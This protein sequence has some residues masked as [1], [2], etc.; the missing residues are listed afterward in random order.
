MSAQRVPKRSPRL[1]YGWIIVAAMALMGFTQSAETFNV[2]G[3]FLKPL[4]QE[5][6][7]SR[8]DF[9]G[10]TSLGSLLGGVIALGIGPMMDRFGARV[11]LVLSLTILGAVFLLMVWM[12]SLWQFYAL[13]VTG[14]ML[15]NGVLGVAS[16]IIIPKWFIAKRG[17]AVAVGGLGTGLGNTFTPLYTQLLVST[18]GWRSAAATVGGAIWAISLLPVAIFLRRQPEDLGLLPDGAQPD[19]DPRRAGGAPVSRA[20]ETSYPL[21]EVV[22]FSSFYLLVASVC[23]TWFIRTG[24]TLHMIA[25]FTDRGLTPGMAV[26]ALAVNSACAGVAGIG[27]GLSAERYPA[28]KSLTVGSLLVGAGLL[29]LMRV[30]SGPE[31]LLWGVYWG[32][33]QASSNT[34]QRVIFADYFGRRHLGAIQGVVRS[35]QT[36]AQALGPLVAALAY[37]GSGSYQPVFLV[38]AAAAVVGAVCVFAARPPVRGPGITA[39]GSTQERVVRR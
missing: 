31:A 26:M 5:F 25:Y 6:G 28:R 30:D 1:Y 7:W 23:T 33:A 18:R 15:S 20:A 17:R 22:R 24:I 34:L 19:A 37:D 13:Q 10:A 32:M 14:R 3:V 12:T 29:L 8:S 35:V 16:S 21:R 11:A 27:W 36:V 9:A 2:L 39:G 38:F 4:T